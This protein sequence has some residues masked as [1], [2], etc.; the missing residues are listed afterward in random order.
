M[1]IEHKIT[2]RTIDR[3]IAAEAYPSTTLEI[4]CVSF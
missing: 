1:V 2:F 4:A 3:G